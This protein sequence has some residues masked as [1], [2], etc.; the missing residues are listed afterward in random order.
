MRDDVIQRQLSDAIVKGDSEAAEAKA[1]VLAQYAKNPTEALDDLYDA[2]RTAESLHS[3]GE[4]DDARFVA[5]ANA[6]RASLN[7]LKSSLV[8][9]QTRFTARICV[10]AVSGGSDVMSSI[11]AALFA[12]AGHQV[13]DLSRSATPREV[14]R[15]AEQSNAELLVVIFNEKDSGLSSEFAHEYESGGFRSKFDIVAFLR[16]PQEA[17]V[18]SDSFAF[19][20]H[21]S[22]ELLSKTTEFVIRRRGSTREGS[23]D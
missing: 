8:P 10:G 12:A 4:Y 23:T 22:L 17:S 1:K 6:A 21:D 11:M 19:A 3:I 18:T 5:S 2:F 16:T 14:L 9:R 15:N 13:T 20:A 7:V